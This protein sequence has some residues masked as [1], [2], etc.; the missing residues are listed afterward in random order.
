MFRR[1]LPIPTLLASVRHDSRLPHLH[2][3]AGHLPCIH[4]Y[5]ISS[6]RLRRRERLL[7]RSHNRARNPLIHIRNVSS[8]VVLFCTTV[9]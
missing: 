9:V 2:L 5:R 1:Y 4:S 8:L 3:R 6:H 7:A